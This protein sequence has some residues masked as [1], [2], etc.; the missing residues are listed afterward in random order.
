MSILNEG[1]GDGSSI[2]NLTNNDRYQLINRKKKPEIVC[3]GNPDL[4][5]VR[6]FE[7]VSLVNFFNKLSEQLND[8]VCKFL[9]L[10]NEL[11]SVYYICTYFINNTIRYC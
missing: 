9:F 4:Q 3:E 5:P 6:T 10:F 1:S 7:V 11:S 2:K 8:E